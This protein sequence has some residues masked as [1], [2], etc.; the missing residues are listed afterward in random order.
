M[1]TKKCEIKGGWGEFDFKES[2]EVWI[3]RPN[4]SNKIVSCS[5]I[6]D[7]P[8]D[9]N[10]NS[11]NQFLEGRPISQWNVRLRKL[12]PKR[13]IHEEANELVIHNGDCTYV[14]VPLLP[15]GLRDERKVMYSLT[16]SRCGE[17]K[18][19]IVSMATW[20]LSGPAIAIKDVEA[21]DCHPTMKWLSTV[22]L[23]NLAKY[24][25]NNS[26]SEFPVSHSL[27]NSE[28]YARTYEKLKN[29]YSKKISQEWPEV[30]DPQKYVTEDV[31]IASYLLVLWKA[32]REAKKTDKLQT[33]LDIGCGN[34]L[35]THIL[36]CE[37][38]SS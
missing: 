32:E 24:M 27:I 20:N 6:S 33:F 14:F 15:T 37:G 36:N 8:K 28:Q 13:S 10:L 38:V 22:L 23:P 30:T 19:S 16:H 11:F 7:P 35:L 4:L 31:A 3:K 29:K 34:G 9:L 25:N 17:Q 12:V 18:D 1:W 5:S 2:V 26:T 21:Q